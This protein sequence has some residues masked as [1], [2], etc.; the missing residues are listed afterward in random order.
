MFDKQ[1]DGDEKK[2]QESLTRGENCRSNATWW[3]V[4]VLRCFV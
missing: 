3:M 1:R 2:V 4:I